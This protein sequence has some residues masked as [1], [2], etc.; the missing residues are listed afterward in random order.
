[1]I[2]FRYML[3]NSIFLSVL[4][5]LTIIPS[6][7]K[8]QETETPSSEDFTLMVSVRSPLDVHYGQIVSFKVYSGLG[9]KTTDQVVLTLST[10]PHTEVVCPHYECVFQRIQLDRH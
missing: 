4:L 5:A 3:S 10:P 2:M 9:P 8:K 7:C 1:M 6:A